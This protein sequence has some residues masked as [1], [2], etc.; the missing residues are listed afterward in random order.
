LIARTLSGQSEVEIVVKA[1][2]SV[3]PTAVTAT[4]DGDQN[5]DETILDGRDAGLI[6][7]K[8]MQ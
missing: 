5:G 8:A 6:V 7:D 1:A 2:E 4:D 3:V